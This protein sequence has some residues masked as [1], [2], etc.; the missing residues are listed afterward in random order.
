MLGASAA[1]PASDAAPVLDVLTCTTGLPA[2]QRSTRKML[3]AALSSVCTRLSA[4]DSKTTKQ[5]LPLIA[6]L[7]TCEPPAP[8]KGNSPKPVG[9]STSA[10]EP[11]GTASAGAAT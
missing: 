10:V 9:R 3:N 8:S 11:A 2:V 7:S 6:C 1:E 4:V 5:P